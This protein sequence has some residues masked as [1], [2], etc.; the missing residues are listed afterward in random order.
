VFSPRWI[1]GPREVANGREAHFTSPSGRAKISSHLPRMSSGNWPISCSVGQAG[2]EHGDVGSAAPWPDRQRQ[3]RRKPARC[4]PMMVSGFTMTRTS[5]QRDQKPRRD[6]QKSRS[7]EFNIGPGTFAFEH[8]DL[9]SEREDFK[10]RVG[11]TAEEDADH[12]E[13]GEDEFQHEL[14]LVTQRNVGW[15]RR[16]PGNAKR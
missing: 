9:L 14:T 12:G 13:G 3:Y 8:R 2:S 1:F 5:L 7:R 6:V 16:R 10:S 4:Q 11:P 15:P